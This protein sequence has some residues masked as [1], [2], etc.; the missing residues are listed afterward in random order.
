VIAIKTHIKT[1]N[2][3][4][5]RHKTETIKTKR[6]NTAQYDVSRILLYR[7]I[8]VSV[9][10]YEFLFR[11]SICEVSMNSSLERVMCISVRFQEFMDSVIDV[12]DSNVTVKLYK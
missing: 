3:V 8:G 11:Q 5:T 12:F 2:I 10:V 1:D 6:K 4:H 7:G 9:M